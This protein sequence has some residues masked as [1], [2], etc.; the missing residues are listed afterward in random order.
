MNKNFVIYKS[1]LQNMSD[2]VMTLN[3]KGKIITFNKAAADILGLDRKEV[4]GKKFAEIFLEYDGND[5]F[6]QAIL[7]AVY[8]SDVGHSKVVDVEIGD[9]RLSLSMST[10]FL[11]RM[12][13]GKAEKLGVIAVF[14]DMTE[15][16]K[17]RDAEIRLSEDLKAKHAELQG[18][19]LKIEDSNQ[20]LKTVLKRVQVVRI[21]A[22]L[23]IIA[24]FL[25][26]GLFVWGENPIMKLKS[27][28]TRTSGQT[29]EQPGQT[30]TIPVIPRPVSSTISMPGILEPLN[31]VNVVSPFTGKVKDKKFDYGDRVE[32]GQVLLT[33]D[34]SPLEIQYRDARAALIKTLQK[35]R[36]LKNWEEE[37]EVHTAN[38][39][40]TKAK[41]SLESQKRK[42]QETERLYQKGI[43]P[44]SEYDSAKEQYRNLELDYKASQEALAEVLEKGD[45]ENLNI[46]RFEMEN[47]KIKAE[48]LKEK[49]DQATLTAPVSGVVIRPILTAN[50]KKTETLQKGA[51]FEQG[52]V[53]VSVGDLERMSVKTNVDEVEISKIMEGQMVMVTGDAFAG[54]NLEGKVATI[55]SQAT[56]EDRI[57]KFDVT[58][59]VNRLTPGQQKVVRL[60][61][62]ANLEVMIY[63]N[64]DALMV[65]IVAVR[66]KGSERF[67]KIKD[68]K[69]QKI[70]D[71]KVETG[72]TTL[73][74]VEITKGLKAGDAVVIPEG[75]FGGPSMPPRP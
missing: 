64:P 27:A 15:L 22:T 50:T 41:R 34:T 74:A 11:Q 65:P 20:H 37:S 12:K 18:A 6:N 4:L 46:A 23:F 42:L 31:V 67:V 73:D 59:H 66:Q 70:E 51:A 33:M 45:R 49:I 24:I 2:G 62:S 68:K 1:I 54:I 39:S 5:D 7:D 28:R 8:E 57:P 36:E 60:G 19:Y 75:A 69:T 58:V 63:N 25:G 21:I 38:R 9:K 30:R 52:Q 40:L 10:S 71:I 32:K 29:P 14:S 26:T 48:D 43:V 56:Q 44:A 13:D 47:A 3:L 61:M 16:K 17:L 35:F 72:I 53:V 55:S